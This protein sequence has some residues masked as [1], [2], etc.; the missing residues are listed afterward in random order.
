MPANVIVNVQPQCN[1]HFCWRRELASHAAEFKC[2]WDDLRSCFL[3][4]ELSYKKWR[5]VDE[6]Q[7]NYPAVSTILAGY[8]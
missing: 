1:G 6:V 5:G 2:Y 4:R 7:V 3:V 8:A